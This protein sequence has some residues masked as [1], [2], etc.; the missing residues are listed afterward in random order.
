MD[1]ADKLAHSFLQRYFCMENYSHA[2]W[3]QRHLNLQSNYKVP[4]FS[5]YLYFV[6][7]RI[8]QFWLVLHSQ[9][10]YIV[11][12]KKSNAILE[13]IEPQ[14]LE[15]KKVATS[16][17]KDLKCNARSTTK[18]GEINFAGRIWFFEFFILIRF[19]FF[20]ILRHDQKSW[21]FKIG[22]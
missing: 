1:D 5:T 13:R 11:E 10:L 17:T 9:N 20:K 14:N 7:W 8:L 4:A 16:L 18:W 3:D 2:K 19:N 15:L 6:N 21:F 12:N 22:V